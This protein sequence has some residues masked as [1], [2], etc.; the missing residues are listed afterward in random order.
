[1]CIY[2]HTYIYNGILFSHK[3]NEILPFS[4]TKMD[5]ESIM[6]SKIREKQISYDFT[7]M[8]NLRKKT[9]EQRGKKK[10]TPNYRDP[11]RR[12]VEGCMK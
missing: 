7:Y 3:K 9:N 1:M 8:W 6:L 5:L 11:E 2:I 4:I 10:E 12:E